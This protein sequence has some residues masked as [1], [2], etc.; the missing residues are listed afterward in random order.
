M[1]SELEH[2]LTDLKRLTVLIAEDDDVTARVLEI[3]LKKLG[4]KTVVAHDGAAAWRAFEESSPAIVLTDWQM[5]ELS[6]IEL[7]KKIRGF[8]KPDYTYIIVL[9][10]AF[11]SKQ[12]YTEAM[13]AGADDFLRKPYD[14]DELALKL[15]AA[16]RII[17]FHAQV[18]DLRRLIPVCAYCKKI[19]DDKNYW[20][21]VEGYLQKQT[22]SQITHGI[23]PSCAIKYFDQKT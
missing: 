5:P 19:R 14:P 2:I 7:C 21:Q 13:N 10:A 4:L 1:E 15:R 18:R 23:C 3:T 20:Q 11:Q 8:E 12:N 6:G 16:E 22:G 9:T 17:G